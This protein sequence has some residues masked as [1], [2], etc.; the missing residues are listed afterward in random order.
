MLALQPLTDQPPKN[1]AGATLR[2][3][4]NIFTHWRV[5]DEDAMSL[6]GTPRSTYYRWRRNPD[7]ARLSRDALERASYLFGIYKDLQVL[8]PDTEAADSWVQRPNDAPL[9]GGRTPLERLRAGHVADLFVVRQ[10]L[11]AARAG[12]A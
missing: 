3:L 6:L 7:N 11:D 1:V 12:K 4:F 2:T 10:F 8:L 9:F 5:E